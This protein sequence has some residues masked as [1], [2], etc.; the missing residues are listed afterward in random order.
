MSVFPCR[1]LGV[2]LACIF[3]LFMGVIRRR[4]G[5]MFAPWIAHTFT[6]VV[7][8]GIVLLLAHPERHNQAMQRTA[9]RAAF[10]LLCVCHPPAGCAARFTGLHFPMSTRTRGLSRLRSVCKL[11]GL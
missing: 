10:R 9:S 1:W 8:A 3:G 5:G 11:P 7:I 2:G 4:A 6:D